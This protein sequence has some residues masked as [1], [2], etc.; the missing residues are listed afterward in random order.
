V[1][2]SLNESASTCGGDSG[3]PL[4]AET[5]ASQWVE[6]GITSTSG[7]NCDP[8]YAQYFTRVDYIEPWAQ[9]CITDLATCTTNPAPAAPVATPA[10]SPAPAQAAAPT[11]LPTP[12]A[13][14]VQAPADGT[15][16]GK[17]SQHS[18]H[19]ALTVAPGAVTDLTLKYNLKCARRERGPLVETYKRAIPL[20]LTDGVWGFSAVYRN[21]AGWH[22]SI[23][24]AF[25]DTDTDT[26]AATGHL[27]VLTRNKECRS[28]AVD[29][30]VLAQ[31]P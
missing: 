8:S 16:A 7:P 18:G 20:T 29:W 4:V 25:S 17:S 31:K 14:A 26:G 3:G 1:Q 15:Y 2:D 13:A 21:S 11:P 19:V 23:T 27:T 10:P 6:I 28:G 24:G 22:F 9:G 30:K 12:V 5:D